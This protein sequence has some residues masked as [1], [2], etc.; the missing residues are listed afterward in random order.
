[1]KKLRCPYKLES[2]GVATLRAIEK[3]MAP[4][5]DVPTEAEKARVILLQ[6]Y[7]RAQCSTFLDGSVSCE[8]DHLPR[9]AESHE[10]SIQIL[11]APCHSQKSGE[12]LSVGNTFSI[13][14]R[15]SPHAVKFFKDQAPQAPLV[16]QHGSPSRGN[17]WCVDVVKCRAN[18]WKYS[19]SDWS[20]FLRPGLH[21]GAHGIEAGRLE[22]DSGGDPHTDGGHPSYDAVFVQWL[23]LQGC[24]GVSP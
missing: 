12:E 17:T 6:K 16:F 20:L 13:Q 4:Q 21:S 15:F 1:M 7:R 5:R 22:L 2:I 18:C 19:S 8:V 3:L 10:T 14:S 11:C 23:V 9:I 24:H